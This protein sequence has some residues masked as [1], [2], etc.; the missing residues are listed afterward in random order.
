MLPQY[1]FGYDYCQ[2]WFPNGQNRPKKC[3]HE[4]AANAL[5]GLIVRWRTDS[6][7]KKMVKQSLNLVAVGIEMGV[8]VGI[9]IFGGNWIDIRLGT[10]PVFF[11]VGFGIGLGA[12]AKAVVD[13]ARKV[14]KD[15]E[16]NESEGTEKD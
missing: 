10:E 16:T 11:W 5:I 2:T 15:L 9:G 6:D 12:A 7:G 1:Q 4:K 13:A 14:R 8:A 3:L